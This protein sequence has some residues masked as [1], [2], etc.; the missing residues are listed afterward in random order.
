MIASTCLPIMMASKNHA[1][2][3]DDML[4]DGEFNADVYNNENYRVKMVRMLKEWDDLGV[5]DGK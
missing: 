3:L 4:D 1:K 5:L 2:E